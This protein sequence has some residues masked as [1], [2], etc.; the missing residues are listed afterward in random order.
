MNEERVWMDQHLSVPRRLHHYTTLA[1]LEG[2]ITKRVIWASDARYLNDT[3]ELSYAA[4]LIDGVIREAF[5]QVTDPVL[6]PVLPPRIGV[7]NA[8]AGGYGPYV[9]CFCED[10]D[11]LS[12]WRGYGTGK[13]SFAIGFNFAGPANRDELPLGSFI[14][15]V[16]YDPD[17]QHGAVR[18]V[19]SEWL[20]T[21]QS[22]LAS[23][24]TPKDLFP[25]PA[26]WTL[27]RAFAEHHLCFKHPA[28]REEREWRLIKLVD[29]DAEMRL[30]EHLEW[31]ETLRTS[32]ERLTQLGVDVEAVGIGEFDPDSVRTNAEGLAIKFRSGSFG[33]VPYLELP[34]D[35]TRLEYVTQGPTAHAELARESLDLFL[36]ANGFAHAKVR[37]SST[38]LRPS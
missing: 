2:I 11:L 24:L 34:I 13:P 32:K 18:S 26:I 22:L 10:S 25:Y 9:A 28:F 15:K 33:L 35:G 17:E 16:I 4:D 14:R 6:R 3:S 19:I 31:V 30:P 20:Q 7:A 23:G 37:L 27:Q 8:F 5:A 1:G 29:A 36:R 38:P 12:Q 21:T